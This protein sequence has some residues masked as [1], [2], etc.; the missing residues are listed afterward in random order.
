MI[1]GTFYIESQ[2]NDGRAVENALRVCVER[3]GREKG[4]SVK[5]AV[6]EDV[7]KEGD[8]YSSSVEAEVIFDSL[9]DF[10]FAAM[11]YTP[12]AIV[13]D[14]PDRIKMGSEGFLRVLAE[15]TAFTKRLVEREKIGVTLPETLPEGVS[16]KKKHERIKE[17]LEDDE[18]ES[19]LDQGAM[20]IKFVFEK[21]LTE[22]ERELRRLLIDKKK[23][24]KDNKQ[25][26]SSES[27]LKELKK[28]SGISG[29][30]RDENDL[31]NALAKNFVGVL[32]PDVFI[33]RYKPSWLD[34]DGNA[35]LLG[36]HAFLYEPKTLVEVSV[37]LTP[38]LIE[39]LEPDEFE[40]GMLA[41]QDM[42]LELAAIYFELAHLRLFAGSGS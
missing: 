26:E 22:G 2:G 31:L 38:V 17:G 37:K 40:L 9:K 27:R 1:E 33:H 8:F 28:K 34:S 10:L 35:F 6:Y 5:R 29:R 7:M 30:L 41:L 11:R 12:Y 14:S 18:I 13:L 36:V 23:L 32:G 42:A 4:V 3:L 39:L 21:R 24:S 16:S 25:S 20:R 19:L 15:I